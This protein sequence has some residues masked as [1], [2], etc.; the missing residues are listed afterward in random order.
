M[1][2][3]ACNG[4][5]CT[6]AWIGQPPYYGVPWLVWFYVLA[7]VA[8]YPHGGVFAGYL[9]GYD[10]PVRMTQ[11]LNWV[12]GAGWYDRR[13]MRV[14]PPDGFQTIWSRIV[15]IPIALVIIIAQQFVTQKTAAIVA[16]LVIPMVELRLLFEAA[17]YFIRP[18][19]G[20]NHARL[21][22]L[23]L[24]FST[25]SNYHNF[26]VSGF[27]PG[28]AS[29]HPWYIILGLL[30]YGALARLVIG[31]KSKTS[32]MMLGCSIALLLAVG[33]EPFLLIAGVCVL[34][35]VLAWH[36]RRPQL[37]QRAG[38]GFA[39]GALGALLLLPMHQPPGQLLNISFVEPSIIGPI[40]IGAAAL[41]LFGSSHAIKHS[42]RLVSLVVIIA[43]AA[44]LSIGLI[45]CFPQIQNGA[46]A[47]LSPAERVMVHREHFEA[48]SLLF[49][50][51]NIF[52]LLGLFLP[53]V[54]A[55]G[56]GL[57][58]FL[59]ATSPRRQ[60]LAG[61]YLGFTLTDSAITQ[62]Y[63]R[64]YHHAVSV[65]CGW[66][67]WLWQYLI[68]RLPQNRNYSFAVVA[69]FIALGPFLMLLIPAFGKNAPVLSQVLLFPAELQSVTEPCGLVALSHYLDTHYSKD[70]N[71]LV[72]GVDSSRMLYATN[73]KIDFLNNYPSQDR[74]IDN[75]TFF[76]TQLPDVAKAI[77]RRHQVDLVAVCKIAMNASPLQSGE[78][79]MMFEL[80]E[81]G[82]P[83]PW[84]KPIDTHL[85][86]L[87]HLYE[88]DKAALSL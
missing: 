62:I 16:A 7:T 73:L 75:E 6:L 29:H 50:A 40:L 54:A 79:P 34:L 61:L 65:A 74:F 26:S 49:A 14:D 56:G 18:L 28:E 43:I 66:L 11:V 30:M 24:I 31:A 10:D 8:C 70:T 44:L 87:Y 72:P 9:T 38:C 41:F 64:Y 21:I 57:L 69:L 88:V 84:L 35:V 58:C 42:T 39:A 82:H 83:P 77:A 48:R 3:S 4:L 17:R 36:Y 78:A 68:R 59:R 22:S 46:T 37:I 52:D 71:L 32:I 55:L 47:G 80:L 76:G 45:I 60:A 19:V 13:I 1:I 63:A 12:N 15:D 86:G 27:Y 20:K 23:F 33:I 25:I 81:Y 5:R 51:N 67:L 2:R 85:P 53:L